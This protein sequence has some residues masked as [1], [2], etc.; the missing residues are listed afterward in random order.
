M[1]LYTASNEAYT[2][3]N[4]AYTTGIKAY[5]VMRAY[6]AGVCWSCWDQLELTEI[7]IPEI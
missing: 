4:E 6:T 3:G 5:A 1:I 7:V 2:A